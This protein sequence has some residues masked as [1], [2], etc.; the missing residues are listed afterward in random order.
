MSLVSP[1]LLVNNSE[2]L[3]FLGS[4]HSCGCPQ[5]LLKRF[6]RDLE[7]GHRGFITLRKYRDIGARPLTREGGKVVSGL[8]IPN[9]AWYGT[10]KLRRRWIAYLV[11]H[12][13]SCDAAVL[14]TLHL[15]S[16]WGRAAVKNC[17]I[18]KSLGFEERTIRRSVK[19]LQDAGLII[20]EEQSHAVTSIFGPF[21]KFPTTRK[22]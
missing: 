1:Y 6:L 4:W 21:F 14:L 5:R 17:L 3:N 10:R 22:S 7:D 19:R 11:E 9:R 18:A 12:G 20:K 8:E 2:I 16:V 15:R 13:S